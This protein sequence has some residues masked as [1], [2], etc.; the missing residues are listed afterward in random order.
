MFAIRERMSSLPTTCRW[1]LATLVFAACSDSQPDNITRPPSPPPP[2]TVPAAPP[3]NRPP[4]RMTVLHDA[5]GLSIWPREKP[6]LSLRLF[7]YDVLG[8]P[9]S[10]AWQFSVTRGAGALTVG[11][12]PVSETG[13]LALATWQLDT[14]TSIHAVRVL[15]E[16]SLDTTMTLETVSAAAAPELPALYVL[17]SLDGKLPPF[18]FYEDDYFTGYVYAIEVELHQNRYVLTHEE[19]TRTRTTRYRQ[20]GTVAWRSGVGMLEPDTPFFPGSNRAAYDAIAVL[21]RDGRLQI[22]NR[23]GNVWPP[24]GRR[25][26]FTLAR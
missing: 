1:M 7:A 26:D 19:R 14:A 20:T 22:A 21:A 25:Y 23:S 8:M 24:I 18:F 9:A 11:P 3:A 15:L 10:G 13:V 16:P 2:V 17:D 12:A 4:V 5:L 6:L